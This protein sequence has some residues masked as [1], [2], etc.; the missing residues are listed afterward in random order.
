MNAYFLW[1]SASVHRVRWKW[2]NKGD[3]GLTVRETT[4]DEFQMNKVKNLA[5]SQLSQFTMI[6][7]DHAKNKPKTS[8][9]CTKL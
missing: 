3:G 8:G 9:L 7:F 2:P 6:N 4:S 1:K 5:D